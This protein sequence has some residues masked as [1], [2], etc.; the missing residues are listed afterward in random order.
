VPHGTS[1]AGI[2]QAQKF[3]T[4]G[5]THGSVQLW[6]AAPLKI[7]AAAAGMMAKPSKMPRP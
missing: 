1:P 3:I 2:G 6:N 7:T 5:H 4:C